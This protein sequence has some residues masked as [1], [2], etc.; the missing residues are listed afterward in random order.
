MIYYIPTSFDSYKYYAI[1]LSRRPFTLR[2]T[3]YGPRS[4]FWRILSLEIVPNLGCPV[5]VSYRL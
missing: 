3:F 1:N 4:G 5:A 2:Y